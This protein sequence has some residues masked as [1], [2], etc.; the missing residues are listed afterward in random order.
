MSCILT[1][2]I[3]FLSLGLFA[4]TQSTC[5]FYLEKQN[6]F[7]AYSDFNT[8]ELYLSLYRSCLSNKEDS[9]SKLQLKNIEL[10]KYMS[11]AKSK[12]GGWAVNRV[13]RSYY[14][15]DA[16]YGP[17]KKLEGL[18]YLSFE[19]NCSVFSTTDLKQGII[20]DNG[21]VILEPVYDRVYF[22]N[23]ELWVVFKNGKGGIVNNKGQLL[24]PLIY[25][26][27]LEFS[28]GL[29]GVKKNGRYGFID[30]TG[31]LV[32]PFKYEHVVPFSEGLA[33]A[34]LSGKYG[35]VSVKGSE[36][37]PFEYDAALSF[38]QNIAGVKKNNKWGIIDKNKNILLD[39]KFDGLANFDEKS[40][41]A[42]YTY[43]NTK[44]GCVSSNG[45]QILDVK[46]DEVKV[47][48]TNF[49]RIM[50]NGNF[51]YYNLSKKHFTTNEY[52]MLSFYFFDGLARFRRNGKYGFLDTLFN[53]IISPE[54][55]D[56]GDVFVCDMVK[57]KRN[58]KVGFIKRNGHPVIPLEF[59]RIVSNT[60]GVILLNKQ[61]VSFLYSERGVLIKEF[62]KNYR[63]DGEFYNGLI[64]F[65][66][67]FKLGFI[68]RLGE[69]VI[70]AKY[71][72]LPLYHT[73]KV[74]AKL[75]DKWGAIDT[76]GKEILPF[77]YDTEKGV[78]AIIDK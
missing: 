25:D 14:F 66:V 33:A 12:K 68:N 22:A 77:I 58:G 55:D 26:D 32:I 10:F 42:Y 60:E 64:R 19:N 9:Q 23:E 47:I 53:E 37:I 7:V 73:G 65:S 75:N 13:D 54:Y 63:F 8:A 46:Y 48:D 31:R 44:E 27:I 16:N 18:T 20:N 29:A 49:I 2:S 35:F 34:K 62:P 39:Y 36:V 70:E 76:Q 51:S 11:M 74:P 3:T 50:S 28:N 1:I 52:E 21:K 78:L 6:K 15:I 17:I 40:F 24:V 71:S 45:K 30:K 5:S 67:G 59:D 41:G 56:A 38:K 43:Q 72:S 69:V 61:S 57:V 4:Q